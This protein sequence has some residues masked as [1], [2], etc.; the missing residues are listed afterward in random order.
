LWMIVVVVLVRPLTFMLDTLVRN[1]AIVP[2]LVN[3]VRWQSHWHVIRQSWTFFQNDFAGR[4]A[5]KIIQA[6]DAIEI[7]VNLAIDAAWY[8]LIFVVVA[9][10]VLAQLDLV[11]LVPIAVWLLLYAILFAITMPL[12]ARYSEEM[13]ED[14][15]VM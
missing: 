14:K 7:G 15:S 5:N 4:I 1:H 2:N 10:I 13:S 3:L 12:I 8:A 9:V 11:L 6:G